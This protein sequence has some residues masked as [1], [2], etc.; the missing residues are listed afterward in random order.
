MAAKPI[1]RYEPKAKPW[2]GLI[3]CDYPKDNRKAVRIVEWLRAVV[4]KRPGGKR[5]FQRL[6][7]R[8]WLRNP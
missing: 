6:G 3:I 8:S 7:I 1:E 4:L 5:A 2:L